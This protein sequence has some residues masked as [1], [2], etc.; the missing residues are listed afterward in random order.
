MRTSPPRR[1][2][3]RSTNL[4]DVAMIEDAR[5]KALYARVKSARRSGP[6]LSE[7]LAGVPASRT[8]VDLDF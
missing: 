8:Y 5:A 6:L 3:R 1:I 4:G 2:C 7:W